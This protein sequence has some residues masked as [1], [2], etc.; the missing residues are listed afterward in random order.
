MIAV[1]V[2]PTDP[3]ELKLTAQDGKIVAAPGG[4]I[5]AES[6]VFRVGTTEEIDSAV[7]NGGPD[8][9]GLTNDTVYYVWVQARNLFGESGWFGPLSAT[10]L[11]V[12]SLPEDT[13]ATSFAVHSLAADNAA[14]AL[15]ELAA[16][17]GGLP[18]NTPATAYA[19]KFG[20]GVN[21]GEFWG[22]AGVNGDPL[23]KLFAAIGTGRYVSVDLADCS[24][25]YS[26]NGSAAAPNVIPD[27][28]A[29]G[30]ITRP[31]TRTGAIARQTAKHADD[32]FTP[33]TTV[34][35]ENFGGYLTGLVLPDTIK[36][37]GAL[38]MSGNESLVSVNF[39]S[40]LQEIRAGAFGATGITSAV[41]SG[42][43]LTKIGSSAFAGCVSL[44]AVDFGASP[45]EEIGEY[46]FMNTAIKEI[47][48][49]E[50]I[51]DED[52]GGY[53]FFHCQSLET[54]RIPADMAVIPN[55]TFA[56]T[57][58]L[59][60]INLDKVTSIGYAAFQ[61][62]GIRSVELPALQSLGPW[63]F[64]YCDNLRSVTLG[65]GLTRLLS[66]AFQD[67]R[68]L[69]TINLEHITAIGDEVK[70]DKNGMAVFQNCTS[71]KRVD[72]SALTFLDF[73][74]YPVFSGC[75]SLAEVILGDNLRELPGGLFSGCTAL[76]SI[77]LPKYLNSLDG[78]FAPGNDNLVLSIDPAAPNYGVTQDGKTI[79]SKSGVP[80]IVKSIAQGAVTIPA[81]IKKI[82]SGAFESCSITSVTMTSVEEIGAYAFMSCTNLE[83]VDLGNALKSLGGAVFF[84]CTRL[85][86]IN[87][88][89]VPVIG[90]SF[91][92]DCTMESITVPA[93]VTSLGANAFQNAKI[94]SIKIEAPIGRLPA[95]L[96]LG[97]ESDVVDLP[98][99]VTHIAN[100][101]FGTTSNDISA[102]D[103]KIGA[104]ILRAE[105]PPTLNPT[106]NGEVLPP[107]ASGAIGA[108][109]VPDGSVEAY[110]A[111]DGGTPTKQNWKKYGA[112]GKIR[113]LSEYK[114]E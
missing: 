1:G 69:E 6:F 103:C 5:G 85:K 114:V 113:P 92:Y 99:S 51:E 42:G 3:T 65:S 61:F 89:S 72:L 10:P 50:G 43:N 73:D 109:Y 12:H 27:T 47:T 54:V 86:A 81:E 108:I 59:A 62:S 57:G 100:R 49:P 34:D 105:T 67:C 104:V 40:A 4:S 76:T 112:A 64:R 36:V 87:L 35:E 95:A 70:K 48:L 53:V 101:G 79:T 88:E 68:N 71:L 94:R 2:P 19:V 38:F 107:A 26:V 11:A 13:P 55:G 90:S 8:L 18:E 16:Y 98:S 80:T 63:A 25:D 17:L 28:G 83:T 20:S 15:I 7:E 77:R 29:A 60:N 23:K 74:K 91:F 24:F 84:G 37:I 52:F 102:H 75:T 14:G 110:K 58:S 44:G 106:T 32:P 46:A 93:T 30:I 96:F 9:S 33:L 97:T 22:E 78:H 66:S 41:F 82:G 39:P 21:I 45:L 111:S 56:Y 31:A